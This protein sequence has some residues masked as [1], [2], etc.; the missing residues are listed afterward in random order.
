MDKNRFDIRRT[1]RG[2][3]VINADNI[4]MNEA[5]EIISLI[6]DKET[7]LIRPISY[8]DAKNASFDTL[9]VVLQALALYTFPTTELIDFL[10]N[11][12]DDGNPDFAPDAI[13]ICAGSGWIGRNL[14]IPMTDSY[15]QERKDIK[16]VYMENGCVPIS[17]PKDVEKLDAISA[18][19]KYQPE[20]VIGSYVTR[21][22][23]LG[24]RREGNMYGVD[25]GWVVNNCHKFYL[26]GNI[27]V[28]GGDPIMKR[29]HQTFN[30]EWLITRGNSSKARIWV[31]ENKLWH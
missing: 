7:G 27:N 5:L 4:D 11:E 17:Y 29:N 12:I 18:I 6:Q 14:E 8:N 22:W 31:W 2:T 21:K 28:H 9:N 24:S 19:K 25:T 16:E 23:G 15:L 3:S 13:E 26:I 20:F 30:P 10:K 1:G